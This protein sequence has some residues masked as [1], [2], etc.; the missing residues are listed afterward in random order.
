[1]MEMTYLRCSVVQ[2]RRLHQRCY[3]PAGSAAAAVAAAVVAGYSAP[4]SSSTRTFRASSTGARVGVEISSSFTAWT[5]KRVWLGEMNGDKEE[6]EDGE[7]VGMI[8]V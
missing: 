1:M 2:N 7:G 8:G 6:V 4:M 5:P 3:L